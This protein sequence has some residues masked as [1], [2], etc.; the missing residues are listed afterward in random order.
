MASRRRSGLRWVKRF[1]EKIPVGT[2]VIVVRDDGTKVDSNVRAPAEMLGET[3]VVWLDGISGCYLLS[4]VSAPG[5]ELFPRYYQKAVRH[6]RRAER[7]RRVD[8]RSS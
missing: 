2:R 4:R 5:I 7:L 8:D 1:N 6:R 3:P